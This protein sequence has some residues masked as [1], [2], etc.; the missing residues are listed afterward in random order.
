MIRSKFFYL[1]CKWEDINK[2][3]SKLK[4]IIKEEVIQV[5]WDHEGRTYPSVWD[6]EG[7]INLW[8]YHKGRINFVSELDDIMKEESFM[9]YEEIIMEKFIYVWI[10]SYEMIENLRKDIC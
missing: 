2:G 10:L 6:H 1:Q 5:W 8:R 9:Y 7:R 4:E 3:K